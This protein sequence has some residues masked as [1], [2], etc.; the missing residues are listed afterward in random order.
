MNPSFSSYN[1]TKDEE[2]L[3]NVAYNIYGSNSSKEITK[4]EEIST[5]EIV[6]EEN[7]N[8]LLNEEKEKNNI[9][10]D[11]VAS[12]YEIIKEISAIDSLKSNSNFIYEL[13]KGYIVISNYDKYLL[14]FDNNYKK[15][16][17]IKFPFMI[18][19]IN[20]L[21]NNEKNKI[22]IF[23][24]SIYFIY[25]ISFD[26]ISKETKIEKCNLSEEENQN[27]IHDFNRNINS[28]I[29]N[30]NYHYILQLKNNKQILCTNYGIYECYNLDDSLEKIPQIVLLEQYTE[31]VLLKDDL[32][33]FKS[34]KQLTNGEDLLTIFNSYSNKII[35]KINNYSFSISSYRL[36][37]LTQNENKKTL[38]CSCTKYSN[39]QKNGI[40]LVNFEFNGQEFETKISFEEIESFSV[41]C[42][43][44][45]NNKN[46]ENETFLLVGG[47]DEEYNRGII[48][49]YKLEFNENET[50]IEFLQNIELGDNIEG[51]ISYI[52]QLKNGKIIVSC[53]NGNILYTAPNLDGYKDDLDDDLDNK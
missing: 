34:N 11:I 31:G 48:K 51:S 33:C 50:N 6:S 28:D 32:I 52:C 19:S 20:E 36:I 35:K 46:K 53:G 21:K 16:L 23:A 14:V 7:D 12:K 5:P 38:I 10:N 24:C 3:K 15:I 26:L 30:Y 44:K 47:V 42:I 9:S 40:L 45:L 17:T 39:D 25:I 49:L 2:Y 22:K 13:T 18:N 29:K 27:T 41:N 43:C 37:L 1:F 8:S 4:S